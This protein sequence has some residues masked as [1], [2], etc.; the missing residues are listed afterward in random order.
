M[1][2]GKDGSIFFSRADAEVVCAS[3]DALTK[4]TP[5]KKKKKY[6]H[7]CSTYGGIVPDPNNQRGKEICKNARYPEIQTEK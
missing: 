6:R 7:L 5:I 1:H 3:S 2:G 4:R